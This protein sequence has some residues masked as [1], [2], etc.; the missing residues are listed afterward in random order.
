MKTKALF[1]A[2]IAA[3]AL[4]F[5]AVSCE[6][7]GSGNGIYGVTTRGEASTELIGLADE[8]HHAVQAAVGTVTSR[9]GSNDS[10]AIAAAQAVVDAKAS[11]PSGTI[12]LYFAPSTILGQP[13]SEKVTLKSWTF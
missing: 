3:L 1:V 5:T 13:D 9:S 7:Q 4:I 10:K 11:K 2:L 12:I 6:K 8:M